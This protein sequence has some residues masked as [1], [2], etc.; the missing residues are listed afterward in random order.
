[1]NIEMNGKQ[2]QCI[3]WENADGEQTVTA[4]G[5]V[6]LMLSATYHGDR[7]EFWIIQFEDMVEVARHNCKYIASV[8]WIKT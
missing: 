3:V 6:T 4:K 5:Q 7:D 2:V 1:M 8:V